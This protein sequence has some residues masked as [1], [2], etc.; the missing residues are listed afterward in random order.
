MAQGK[1]LRISLHGVLLDVLGVG[2]LILGKSGVGKTECA[3]DLVMH[4]HRLV[5]DDLIQI[6]K[7]G[8]GAV[9]G[10]SHELGRHHMEIRGLGIIDIEQLFGISATSEKKQIDLVIELVDPEECITDRLGL[11][12]E[13]Y[14]IMGLEIPRKRIPVRPGR[15]LTAIVEVATRDHL[16]KKRGYHAAREFERKLLKGLKKKG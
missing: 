12:T 10:F 13:T 9:H 3:L 2:V 15:N 11:E 5:A 7:G 16:L 14:T 6:E 1:S 8:G 4:G